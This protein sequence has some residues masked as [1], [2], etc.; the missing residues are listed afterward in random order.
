MQWRQRPQFVPEVLRRWVTPVDTHTTG[1]LAQDL[2]VVASLSRGRNRWSHPLHPTLRRGDRALAL[3]PPDRCGKHHVGQLGRTGEEDV[4]D[5]EQV[6]AGQELAGMCDVGLG[7]GRVLPQDVRS[8]NGL[9]FHGLEHEG[10]V[11][12]GIGRDLGIPHRAEA[13]PGGG[14]GDVG[15]TRQLVRQRAH[16]APAL[17]VVLAAERYEP[18][19]PSAH[20]ARQQRQGA[21]GDDVVDC[22][23]VPGDAKGPQDLGGTGC[24]VGLGH[25]GDDGR[26]QPGELGTPLEGVIGNR[27]LE[28]LVARGRMVDERSVR[29]PLADDV[30]GHGVGQRDVCP[31]IQPQPDVGELGRRGAARVDREHPTAFVQ[32]FQ[33]VVEV[34]GVGLAGVGTP[35]EDHVGLLHLLV[36]AGTAA[37]TEHC[38]QT[39]DARSVS[40]AVAGVDVVRPQRHPTELLSG[41]VHL[42]GALGTREE[43]ESRGPVLVLD[44]RE[45]VRDPGERLFPRHRS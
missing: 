35:E 29:Q 27:S 2:V 41:V 28:R 36:G 14:I 19:A 15:E 13:C 25:L 10:Q 9:G 44:G 23:V 20:V 38:R 42:V 30:V 3:G 11:Q 24:G 5:D 31:K 7:V 26:R 8:S 17:N 34:D 45:A 4:L 6:E 37:G 16:V 12:T 33:H 21:E 18:A 32:R 43:G 1:Q 22:V 40:G 39:D